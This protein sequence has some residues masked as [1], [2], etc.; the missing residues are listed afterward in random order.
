MS[1]IQTDGS[2]IYVKIVITVILG[3][4]HKNSR[5]N[6]VNCN[7]MKMQYMVCNIIVVSNNT[8]V[9]NTRVLC[10]TIVPCNNI[11]VCNTEYRPPTHQQ[12]RQFLRIKSDLQ[13]SNAL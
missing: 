10:N 1:E 6:V 2:D 3:L 13:P 9:C 12:K 11:V 7:M 4:N 8:V 5:K